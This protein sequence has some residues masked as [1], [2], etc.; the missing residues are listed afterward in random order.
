MRA[1]DIATAYI[2]AFN[3]R[4]GTALSEL[5]HEEVI[6]DDARGDRIIGENEARKR[7]AHAALSLNWAMHDTMIM[8]DESGFNAAIHCTLR[9]TYSEPMDGLPAANGQNFDIPA[10]IF[11]VSDDDQITQISE[12][13]AFET[14]VKAIS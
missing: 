4:D 5:L 12:F 8:T 7:I 13:F 11:L 3:K 10:I 6:H 1:H 9:G 2:E 14:L